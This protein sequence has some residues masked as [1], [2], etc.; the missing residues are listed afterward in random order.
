[1]ENEIDKT[2]EKLENGLPQK[3]DAKSATHNEWHRHVAA[4]SLSLYTVHRC[5]A[6][7][8]I[9][10]TVKYVVKQKN[11][12]TNTNCEQFKRNF[13]PSAEHN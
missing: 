6:F 8:I 2:N 3:K 1:M 9:G 10:R 13:P 11:I 5:K 7:S 12:Y 4:Q